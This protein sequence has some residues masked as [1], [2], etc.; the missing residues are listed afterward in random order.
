M[1]LHETVM[2]I[3]SGKPRWLISYT[4]THRGELTFTMVEGQLHRVVNAIY[5]HTSVLYVSPFKAVFK[6]QNHMYC[7][8]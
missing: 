6:V 4:F 8:T 3:C 7:K 1:N 5:S 2:K